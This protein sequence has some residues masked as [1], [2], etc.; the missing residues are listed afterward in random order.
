LKSTGKVDHCNVRIL[1]EAIEHDLLAVGH[2]I[3]VPH[4]NAGLEICQLSFLTGVQVDR[5]EIS[6]TAYERALLDENEFGTIGNESVW[7][8]HD[9]GD[10]I[11]GSGTGILSGVIAFVR[12]VDPCSG[13]E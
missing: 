4:L 6:R 3:K 10:R 5:V 9:I 11:S 8:A 1:A 2:D 7:C 12:N 13:S